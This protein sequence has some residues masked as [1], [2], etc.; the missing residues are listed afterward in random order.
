MWESH[1]REMLTF[2]GTF[3]QFLE[4]LILVQKYIKISQKSFMLEENLMKFPGNCDPI[5]LRDILSI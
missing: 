4:I 3:V 2:G 5:Q 1:S